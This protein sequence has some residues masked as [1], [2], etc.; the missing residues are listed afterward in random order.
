M[1]AQSPPLTAADVLRE[2]MLFYRDDAPVIIDKTLA[3]LKAQRVREDLIVPTRK[4]KEEAKKLVIEIAAKLAPYESPKLSSVETKVDHNERFV[5]PGPSLH[6]KPDEWVRN[7]RS[8]I[9]KASL[10]LNNTLSL[11]QLAHNLSDHDE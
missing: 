10:G 2:M 3:L 4:Y 1:E 11:P 5:V 7:V 9:S 8:E 6:D